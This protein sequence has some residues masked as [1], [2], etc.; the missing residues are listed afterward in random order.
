MRKTTIAGHIAGATAAG[1]VWTAGINLPAG[2][3]DWRL[4]A[5]GTLPYLIAALNVALIHHQ[6]TLDGA[7]AAETARRRPSPAPVPTT[8]IRRELAR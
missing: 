6:E 8:A 1:A 3:V 4:A 2:P 5:V 7:G